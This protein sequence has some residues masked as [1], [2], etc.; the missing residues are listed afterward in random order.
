MVMKKEQR[1]ALV[2]F[3]Q[4]DNCTAAQRVTSDLY[5]WSELLRGAEAQSDD[6]NVGGLVNAIGCIEHIVIKRLL[7]LFLGK[8]RWLLTDGGQGE[9]GK[10]IDDRRQLVLSAFLF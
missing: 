8:V 5:E 2:A 9:C 4:R 7:L 6:S 3:Y 10:D 1:L